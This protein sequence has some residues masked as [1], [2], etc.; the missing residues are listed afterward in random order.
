MHLWLDS[1]CFAVYVPFAIAPSVCIYVHL[2]QIASALPFAGLGE[3]GVLRGEGFTVRFSSFL[4]PLP[5]RSPHP[6]HPLHHCSLCRAVY[7]PFG[8]A[9]SVCI[10][11]HLWQIAFALP[12]GGLGELGVLRGEGFT[13]RFSLSRFIRARP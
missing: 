10:Y 13:V 8:I 3:L 7:V 6:I 11:V 1:P 2:W 5:F 12:F 9:P 4:F